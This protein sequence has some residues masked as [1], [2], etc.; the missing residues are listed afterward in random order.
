M[1]NKKKTYKKFIYSPL[2]LLILFLFLLVILRA[3]WGVYKKQEISA[4][5]L[6][7][8]QEQLASIEARHKE[9]AASVD[10]LKTDKGIEAEIRSKF[11][12]VR[13]GESVAVIIGGDATTTP[14]TVTS[15]SKSWFSRLL[16]SIGL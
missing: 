7:K 13:E 4:Q 10:Y 11:R 5:Y 3:V 2:T 6:E 8:E 9:L 15:P 12:V 14:T 1:L 16:D